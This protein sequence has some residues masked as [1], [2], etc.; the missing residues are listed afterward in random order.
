MHGPPSFIPPFIKKLQEPVVRVRIKE[1]INMQDKDNTAT[2]F[3][4]DVVML[5]LS[6]MFIL[7]SIMVLKFY[8]FLFDNLPTGES[9]FFA[10]VAPARPTATSPPPSGATSQEERLTL[11]TVPTA[12]RRK[13]C[14]WGQI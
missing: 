3:K 7:S 6:C 5:S 11:A 13:R 12:V 14:A 10:K 2:S 1:R 9:R 8:A 4:K